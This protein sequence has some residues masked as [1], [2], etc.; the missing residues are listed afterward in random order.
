MMMTTTTKSFSNNLKSEGKAFCLNF[1]NTAS[2][3][4][5]SS[6][7]NF[8]PSVPQVRASSHVPLRGTHTRAWE[9]ESPDAEKASPLIRLPDVDVTYRVR[10]AWVLQAGT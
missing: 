4:L 1:E 8:A 9:S 7:P 3:L 2:L 5:H 6:L 10:P